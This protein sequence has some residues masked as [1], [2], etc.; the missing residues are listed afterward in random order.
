MRILL[1]LIAGTA[2]AASRADLFDEIVRLPRG[3]WRALPVELR[4]RPAEIRA[5][6][7]VVQGQA[8][9]R[10]IL[11]SSEAFQRYRRDQDFRWIEATQ[12]GARGELRHLIT[13]PGNYAVLIDN[14]PESGLALVDLKLS[15]DYTD[16]Y[17][18]FRPRELD[19]RTRAKVVALSLG[20]F[21][22]VA[23]W[24]G[25]RLMGAVRR[26]NGSG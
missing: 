25:W 12:A 22:L 16:E 4:Q 21:L 19:P 6:Y 13:R 11:M 18:S 9:V 2:M 14:R 26:R 3:Q 24:A 8:K 5:R 15:L 17:T 10:L 7:Q 1:L 20:G 23:G